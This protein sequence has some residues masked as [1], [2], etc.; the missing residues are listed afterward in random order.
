LRR[1]A[2][3]GRTLYSLQRGGE[4]ERLPEAV[5]RDISTPD[6]VA[7]GHLIRQLDLVICVDTMVAHL[8]GALGCE[9]W[10]LLHADCDWRWPASGSHTFWYP[11]LRLFHQSTEGVWDDV[12]EEVRQMLVGRAELKR[13]AG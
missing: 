10:V 7:L 4:I 6:I 2:G 8:A 3:D 11:T 5:A 9:A 1:L 13:R 12:I